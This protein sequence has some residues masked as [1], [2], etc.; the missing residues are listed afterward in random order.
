MT[1]PANRRRTGGP[2]TPIGKS[3]AASN[4][5]KIGTY[6]VSTLMPGESISEF[7]QILTRFEQDFQVEDSIESLIVRQIAEV[8]W[9]MMRLDRI[10]NQVE[11]NIITRPIKASE[12]FEMG[13]PERAGVAYLLEL[14]E[15]LLLEDMEALALLGN[16]LSSIDRMEEQ[17]A[18]ILEL[19]ST[20]PDLFS[21]IEAMQSYS[22]SGT[23]A[24]QQSLV[25]VI[26]GLRDDE[27]SDRELYA[28]RV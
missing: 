18:K 26:R 10:R 6:S 22:S 11:S 14:P 16:G 4:S 25:V 23:G 21:H 15:P 2:K 17:R 9:K 7:E 27:E 5:L 3:V 24:S 20:K 1:K 13:F 28:K 12:I 19:Q 8:T